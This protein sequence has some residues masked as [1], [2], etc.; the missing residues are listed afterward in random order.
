MSEKVSSFSE[1]LNQ[2]L[3]DKHMSQ[4]ELAKKSGVSASSISDWLK[5]K[6]DAKQDKID[7]IAKALNVSPTYL[8]GYDVSP[9]RLLEDRPEIIKFN[10]IERIPI[11]GQIACGDPIMCQENFEGFFITDPSMISADFAIYAD[12]DSMIDANIQ[13]GD[14]VFIKQTPVV[15]NGAICAVLIDDTATLKRFYKTDNQI[16]L[17]PENN[18][19]QP[20]I[21]TEED[22]KD[23]RIL[24]EMVG[25]YSKRN[26]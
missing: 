7:V 10:R 15:E 14:L 12:G 5:N 21:I 4:A 2:L 16:I 11:L 3:M 20:I 25:V 6:Y 23:V 17:Q 26:K 22:M 19:Y 1:R 9:E 18:K 13:D 24:G 8:M